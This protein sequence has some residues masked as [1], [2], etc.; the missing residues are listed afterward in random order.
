MIHAMNA[1]PDARRVSLP[2]TRRRPSGRLVGD[3]RRT[4]LSKWRSAAGTALLEVVGDGVEIRP[5]DAVVRVDVLDETFEHEKHLRAARHIR[6]NGEREHRVVVFAIHPVELVAPHLFDVPR[7]DE[8]VAVRA[9]L[10]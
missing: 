7:V 9:A 6:M 3:M 8:A 5:G 2:E 4:F 1:I 10:D